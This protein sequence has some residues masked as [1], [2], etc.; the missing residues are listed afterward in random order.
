MIPRASVVSEALCAFF[1]AAF[2][3]AFFSASSVVVAFLR[4]SATLG[5][6]GAGVATGVGV[7]TGAGVA[8][9]APGAVNDLGFSSASGAIGVR[10]SFVVERSKR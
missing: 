10:F 8:A 2:F 7:A 1:A 9:G 3:G 4:R 6:V 5:P